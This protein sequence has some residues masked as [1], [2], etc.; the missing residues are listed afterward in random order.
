M[1]IVEVIQMA[2]KANHDISSGLGQYIKKQRD[3]LWK[4]Q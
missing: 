2:V 1:I 4:L 3:N